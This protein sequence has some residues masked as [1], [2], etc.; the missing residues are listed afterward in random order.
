[1]ENKPTYH[2]IGAGIAGLYVAKLLRQKYANARIVVYEAAEK[3]GG[4]CGSFF[5]AAFGCRT[6]NA[7]HVILSCNRRSRDLIGKQRLCHPVRFFDLSRRRFL[8][9]AAC[10]AEAE[11]AIFNTPRAD[12]RAKA[13]TAGKLFPFFGLKAWFSAGDL[14][15]ALCLP[16]LKN[17]DEIKYGYVWNGIAAQNDKITAL[18]FRQ[19]NVKVAPQDVVISAVDSFNYN[20]IMGGYDFD[21]NSI[22]NIF[23]RTSMTLT[24]PGGRQMLGIRGGTAQWLFSAPDY[25]AVTISNSSA[26]VDARDIWKEIC[27]LRGGS[28]AF[29]PHCQVLRHKRATICQDRRNNGKRPVSARTRFSNLLICG[30]WT[31]KNQPCCI[32]TALNSAIRAVKLLK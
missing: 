5:S 11:L 7:T 19:Q 22:C 20:K 17:I 3:P 10:L 21:Y 28:A 12:W 26:P 23:Y 6:D 9:A 25:A 18:K 32:E 15:N 1:M 2:I 24:L 4:R 13:F 16:L 27:T 30:D 8:P 29:M 14:D 31:M